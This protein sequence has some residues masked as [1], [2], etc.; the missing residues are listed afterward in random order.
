MDDEYYDSYND[1]NSDSEKSNQDQIEYQ[2]W[3]TIYNEE[4]WNMWYLMD[5]YL[6]QMYS[7]SK[8]ELFGGI[9]A[10]DF[11]YDFCYQNA[12]FIQGTFDFELWRIHYLN[13]FENLWRLISEF[14]DIIGKEKGFEDFVYFVYRFNSSKKYY[15]HIYIV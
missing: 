3:S 6:N 11:F 15:E 5:D 8:H 4:L 13:H 10:D 9:D 14:S 2:D 7:A 12:P 1:S